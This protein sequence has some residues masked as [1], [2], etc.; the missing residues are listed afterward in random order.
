MI[1]LQWY[2]ICL[3]LASSAYMPA[4]MYADRMNKTLD[5]KS[6]R[7]GTEKNALLCSALICALD[8]K[9]LSCRVMG[10]S[11]SPVDL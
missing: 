6:K 10:L 2:I 11:A 7:I 5:H 9:S 1:E 3:H 4:G 8:F